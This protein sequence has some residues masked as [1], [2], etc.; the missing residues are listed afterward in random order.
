MTTYKA[1]EFKAK[2]LKIMEEVAKTG[3]GVVVTKRGVPMVKVTP[4]EDRPKSMYGVDKGKI[5]IFGDIVSPMPVE[6][7]SNAENADEDLF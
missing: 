2:C 4:I 7:Y 6:W 5:K 1:S 3:E